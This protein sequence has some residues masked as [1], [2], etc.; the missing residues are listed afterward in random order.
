M[1]CYWIDLPLGPD[2]PILRSNM[3]ANMQIVVRRRCCLLLCMKQEIIRFKKVC[4]YGGLLIIIR[5]MIDEGGVQMS[6]RVQVTQ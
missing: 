4:V 2:M 3:Y 1:R 6:M 5:A